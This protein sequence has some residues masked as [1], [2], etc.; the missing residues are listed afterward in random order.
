MIETTLQALRSDFYNKAIEVPAEYVLYL[1]REGVTLF[2]GCA[3]GNRT[4][5]KRIFYDV[6]GSELFHQFVSYH[7]PASNGWIIEL[8]TL[9]ECALLLEQER[10]LLQGTETP[11]QRSQIIKNAQYAL[12]A[13]LHPCLN[14]DVNPAPALLPARLCP[15][16]NDPFWIRLR[17]PWYKQAV[18]ESIVSEMLATEQ[19]T[20]PVDRLSLERYVIRQQ[21]AY[22]PSGRQV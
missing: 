10:Y 7:Y 15:R 1:V 2:I 6:P 20:S 21:L 5:L 13:V 19:I 9:E 12:T 14:I 22:N 11:L 8:L 3:P 18:M 17:R 4:I 16:F